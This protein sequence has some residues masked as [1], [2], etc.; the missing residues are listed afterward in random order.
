MHGVAYNPHLAPSKASIKVYFYHSSAGKNCTL[1]YGTKLTE[2]LLKGEG[3]RKEQL[4]RG[5]VTSA[6]LYQHI[7]NTVTHF[8]FSTP[9]RAYEFRDKRSKNYKQKQNRAKRL[10]LPEDLF[11][12]PTEGNQVP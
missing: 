2:L 12:P 7:A 5:E 10:T 8:R 3:A 11:Q 4:E 6:H 9:A 1:N